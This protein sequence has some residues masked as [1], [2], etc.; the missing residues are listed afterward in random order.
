MKKPFLILVIFIIFPSLVNAA[1]S[2]KISIDCTCEKYE[3]QKVTNGPLS[4][5]GC[6]SIMQGIKIFKLSGTFT[7]NDD[8]I[9]GTPH[10]ILLL[11][12]PFRFNI[13]PASFNDNYYEW[14]GIFFNDKNIENQ[15]TMYLGFT[16]TINR[17]NL[18]TI[19]EIKT[20]F[21]DGEINTTE[22]HNKMVK[23]VDLGF[24]DKI[25]YNCQLV[26]NK[27]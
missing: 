11:E 15:P 13:E 18:S 21:Y 6:D 24:I 27:I 12:E 26:K 23:K 1:E 2:K 16:I 17:N 10:T 20:S 4:D 19:L 14:K 3:I 5:F 8:F 9:I 25:S 7:T 22:G